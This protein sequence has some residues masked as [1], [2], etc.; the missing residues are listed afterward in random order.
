MGLSV[1]NGWQPSDPHGCGLSVRLWAVRQKRVAA[2]RSLKTGGSHP[3]Q[4]ATQS[5]GLGDPGKRVAAIRSAWPPD[6]SHPIR[7]GQSETGGS[8]PI[9]MATRSAWGSQKRVAATRSAWQPPDP[10]GAVR[11]GWQPSDPIGCGLSVRNGWQSE[12]GGSHPIA[13]LSE[14]GGSHPIAVRNGW[15]PPDRSHP[16]AVTLTATQKKRVGSYPRETGSHPIAVD[17]SSHSTCGRSPCQILPT[18]AAAEVRRQYY[19]ET[20]DAT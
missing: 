4:R 17:R 19:G 13:C 6:R 5:S 11:N 20:Y 9:R 7:M 2:T 3:I 14:T 10:H 18:D 1:R 16:I 8:H 12:T 15:Q